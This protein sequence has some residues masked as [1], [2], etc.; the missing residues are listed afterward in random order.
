MNKS[1]DAVEK[2]L[3]ENGVKI[4]DFLSKDNIW[5]Y[6]RDYL[7]SHPWEDSQEL[8]Q[9]NIGTCAFIHLFS[10]ELDAWLRLPRQS[11]KTT[12]LKIC[13]ELYN[14]SPLESK[15]IYFERKIDPETKT[16]MKKDPESFK[17]DIAIVDEAECLSYA[18]YNLIRNTFK[19]SYFASVM[20]RDV[21]KKLI[22]EEDG[23]QLFTFDMY[24]NL[25][26]DSKTPILVTYPV[27]MIHNATFIESFK[28]TLF[29]DDYKREI[30]L[31]RD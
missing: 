13:C 15:A 16:R 25:P 9:L 29:P 21:D 11:G 2:I 10:N 24:N 8:Y 27:E 5:C 4:T 3:K 30:L 23:F 31:Q 1:F 18:D 19:H 7:V 20:I 14:N 12:T 26:T 6:F 17:N 28:A 22:K